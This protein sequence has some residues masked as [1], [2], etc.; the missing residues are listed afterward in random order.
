VVV[1]EQ[2]GSV[3]KYFDNP[4]EYISNQINA[5]IYCIKSSLLDEPALWQRGASMEREV[6]PYLITEGQL[7]S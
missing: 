1:T 2:D 5:G 3:I 6:L 4:V 7:H